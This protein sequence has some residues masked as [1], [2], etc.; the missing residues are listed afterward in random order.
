MA[1]KKR[2]ADRADKPKGPPNFPN[3]SEAVP[4]PESED[5]GDSDYGTFMDDDTEDFLPMKWIGH[6]KKPT[7][8]KKDSYGIPPKVEKRTVEN[9]IATKSSSG[10]NLAVRVFKQ[11]TNIRASQIASSTTRVPFRE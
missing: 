7:D 8:S 3:C 11:S 9:T 5:E 1:K 6:G 10:T 2:T 4:K